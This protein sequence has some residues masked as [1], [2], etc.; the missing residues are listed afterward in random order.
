MS[1]VVCVDPE[2]L[3]A[4]LA[5]MRFL[6]RVLQFVGLER[7]E[8][9]EL[10]PTHLAS[11]GP[12]PRV[13]PLMVVVRRLVEKRLP[14][15]V[16]VVLHLTR[17]NELVSFQGARRVEA[18]AAGLAA[19]RRHIHRRSVPSVDDS[20][21]ASLSRSS[22]GGL[23]APFV[24]T[25]LLV[26][27]QLAVVEKSLSA[28]V[29]H[30]RLGG[31]VKKHVG[32]QLVVLNEALPADF[33][34]ERLFSGVNANVSLQVVLQGEA[35]SARLARKHLPSVDRLVRPERPP[36]CESFAAHRAFVRM[37][38]GVNASVALQR[39]RVPEALAALRALVQL[40]DG[41][42]DLV[43]LQVVFSFEGLPAGGAGERPRVRVHE[44][45]GL[46]VHFSFER[47]LAELALEGSVLPLFVP[48]QVVLERRGVPEFPRALVAGERPLIFVSVHVLHQV[49]LPVEALVT[50]V[51][52]KHL[53]SPPDVCASAGSVSGFCRVCRA[54]VLC[55]GKILKLNIKIII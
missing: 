19:E 32:F 4:V 47:L 49:K 36:L 8:D 20:A 18:L 10:L 54:A 48:Q 33:T 9:D 31:A 16:A 50:D 6:S 28:Q 39:E 5:F 1:E 41:V 13:D 52:H 22:S 21:A 15:C 23:P 2:G 38:A 44:L 27:L 45:M 11:E 3:S 12:L 30:E 55:R 40:F 35:R 25:H 29:A 26:L 14:A 53:P 7:L 17:V 46:Q 24:V 37:L 42:H 34:F 43:S 51:A